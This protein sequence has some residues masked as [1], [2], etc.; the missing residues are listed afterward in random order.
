MDPS[1]LTGRVVTSGGTQVG[2][3]KLQN[4][5]TIGLVNVANSAALFTRKNGFF[6]T[7]SSNG[8]A[9]PIIWALGRA[10]RSNSELELY[11]LD[12]EVGGSTLHQIFLSQNPGT[13]PYKNWNANLIP[14]VAN[15][16]V[17]VGSG[18]LL[19]IFGLSSE[20]SRASQ[21]RRQKASHRV[22]Q[23]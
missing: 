3:W 1:G 7:V 16:K 20:A 14:V 9:S 6:T 13:W 17:F 12:P 23:P 19:T 4:G 15:G 18:Q 5:P 10:S 22:A 2:I 11:A 8:T 21:H